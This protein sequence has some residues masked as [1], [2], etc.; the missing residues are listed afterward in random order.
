MK[1]GAGTWVL[2]NDDGTG[3]G[4]T[5]TGTTTINEGIL[6]LSDEDKLYNNN[7]TDWNSTNVTVASGAT[8]AFNMTAT[9]N[10]TGP[11]PSANWSKQNIANA[12]TG[13]GTGFQ[14]G[15]SFGLHINSG[16]DITLS[17]SDAAKFNEVVAGTGFRKTGEG[18]F[19]VSQNM[20]FSGT[21]NVDAG[22]LQL[23]TGFGNGMIGSSGSASVL[24]SDVVVSSG[25]TLKFFKQNGRNMLSGAISGG[26]TIEMASSDSGVSSD[27]LHITGDGSGFTGTTNIANG[28]LEIGDNATSGSLGG[29]VSLAAGSRITFHAC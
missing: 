25:A 8:L 6:R 3:S 24:D 29:D 13:I 2:G 27:V 21:L 15:S 11:N 22:T 17:N 4:N 19:K 18:I 7:Q 26:G 28:R 1:D 20:I 10:A 14:S 9:S 12:L 5:Y 23:G 16:G